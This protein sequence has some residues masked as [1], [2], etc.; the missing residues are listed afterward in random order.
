MRDEQQIT[1]TLIIPFYSQIW[2]LDRWTELGFKSREE[3]SY[4]Q[5]SSCGVLCLKMAIEG[6]S[7]KKIDPISMIIARGLENNAYTHTH[8]WSHSGLTS[9][10]KSYGI[11]A[12]ADKHLN[13]N[14]LKELLDCGHLIIVSIK[15]A[16]EEEVTL[17]DLLLA[18]RK[19]GGHLALLIGYRAGEGFI[20][21]HTST[22]P[23]YNWEGQVI[24]FE[25]FKT[26]FTGRG[27]VLGPKIKP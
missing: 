15:W 13:E 18:W 27:V 19:R 21:N 4:W 12:Y 5:D 22:A 20:I 6:L 9:M 16:F 24:P 23:G 8:G 14:K 17:R 1:Q 10:A 25:K 2:D 3:A 7:E 11:S 26:G